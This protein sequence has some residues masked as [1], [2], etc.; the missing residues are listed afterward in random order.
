MMNRDDRDAIEGLF[1]R[2]AH[3][4]RQAPHRDPDAEALINAETARLPGAAYYM[5]QTIVVQQQALEAAERRIE[6]LEAEAERR[7]RGGLFGGMFDD[8]HGEAGFGRVRRAVKLVQYGSDCYHYGLVASGFGD[9]A[10]E[11]RLQIYD[12]LAC[13]PVIEGAG[14]RVTD[15]QGHPLTIRSGESVVAVG[16]PGQ[17]EA[18]LKILAG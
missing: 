6:E 5:A 14:G 13:V 17:H 1:D 16:D 2:L 7:G 11:S 3:A 15:W 4:A 8:G 18:V 12:Y 10:I 9:I